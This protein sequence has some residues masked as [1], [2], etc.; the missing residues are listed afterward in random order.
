L[1]SLLFKVW[2]CLDQPDFNPK[3]TSTG[4]AESR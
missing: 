1:A 2:E 4:Q 3:T